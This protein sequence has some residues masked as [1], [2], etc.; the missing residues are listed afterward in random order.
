MLQRFA[1]V[2]ALLWVSATAAWAERN[3]HSNY[4]LVVKALYSLPQKVDHDG[5]TLESEPGFGMGLDLGYKIT[6]N[7]ALEL[8][9]SY[10]ENKVNA[11]DAHH[12]KH[13]YDG[14]YYTYALDL[15]YTYHFTKRIGL[16]GKAGIEMED[17]RIDALD[18]KTTETGL[19]YG[20]A[21]EYVLTQHYEVLVEYEG[22]TIES[23]RGHSL[24]AGVKYNF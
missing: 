18:I 1:L 11:E 24:F 13:T 19:A 16:M 10:D 12:V 6:H 23:P 9:F 20:L 17:E 15:A 7:L 4:Y 3:E 5:H 2:L 22:T 8:D 21:L 14:I